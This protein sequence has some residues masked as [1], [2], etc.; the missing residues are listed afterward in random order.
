M[1][2]GKRDVQAVDPFGYDSHELENP[3][4][5]IRLNPVVKQQ[6]QYNEDSKR[7][8]QHSTKPKS[9]SSDIIEV[10]LSNDNAVLYLTC[11]MCRHLKRLLSVVLTRLI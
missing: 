9:K 1:R 4:P 10:R 11:K 3:V 5:L 6:H 8:I 2:K 7:P